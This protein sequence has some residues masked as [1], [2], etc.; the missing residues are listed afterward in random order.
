MRTVRQRHGR[1]RAGELFHHD[2]VG[3]VA[4]VRPAVLL[5]HGHA[6]G[7]EIAELLPQI[8]GEQILPIDL[9]RARRDLLVGKTSNGGAKRVDGLAELESE[10]RELRHEYLRRRRRHTG[11][12][13][14]W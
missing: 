6:V 9:G 12:D 14:G 8:F 2:D 10:L 7:S 4:E 1:R 11:A 3:E 13:A 5:G